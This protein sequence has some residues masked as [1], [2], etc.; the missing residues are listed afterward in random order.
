MFAY[1]WGASTDWHRA[2][3][4]AGPCH[5][6]QYSDAEIGTPWS[7]VRPANAPIVERVAPSGGAS[8]TNFTNN[9]KSSCE[10]TVGRPSASPQAGQ[11]ERGVTAGPHPAAPTEQVA[12]RS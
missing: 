8:V 2:R 3:Q 6:R 5:I 10:H 12:R 11:P 7:A 4:G 9:S 1:F